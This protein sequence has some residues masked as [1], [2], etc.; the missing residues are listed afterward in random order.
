MAQLIHKSYLDF[1][2][3][4]TGLLEMFLPSVFL[5]FA[6]CTTQATQPK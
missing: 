1:K 5:Q 3:L 4:F 6:D 2:G